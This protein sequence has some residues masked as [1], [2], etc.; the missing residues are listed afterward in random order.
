MK[1]LLLFFL[2]IPAFAGSWKGEGEA[3][4]II[5]TGNL[6]AQNLTAKQATGYEWGANSGLLKSSF[7]QAKNQGVLNARRW[8]TTLRYERAV[9]RLWRIFLGE[10][11]ESDVFAGYQQR[12]GTDLGAKYWIYKIEKSFE[13]STE[14]GYR[15][16]IEN[17]TNGTQARDSLVR[18][19]TQAERNWTRT[20]S[21][22]IW[23]EYLLNLSNGK[24]WLLNGEFSSSFALTSIFSVKLAYLVKYNNQPTNAQKTDTTYTTALLAKF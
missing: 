13:W 18:T 16:Q 12:Y 10:G 23:V 19:Y 7:L 11:L 24:A 6:R 21:S 9:S 1:Y 2:A 3:G 14:L 5:S 20:S 4:V 15:Y 17:R 8:D 22:K